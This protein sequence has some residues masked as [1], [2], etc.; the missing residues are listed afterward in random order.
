MPTDKDDKKITERFSKSTVRQAEKLIDSSAELKAARS[1]KDGL[2]PFYGQTH[3]GKGSAPRTNTFSD[4]Y[5]DNFDRIFKQ[6]KYAKDK[7]KDDK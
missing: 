1:I 4:E 5:Q 6:G 2:K 3:G 7:N